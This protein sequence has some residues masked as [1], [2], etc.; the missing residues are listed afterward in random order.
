[1]IRLKYLIERVT[2]EEI[3]VFAATG[4]E[5]DHIT[6]IK[7]FLKWN[8]NKKSVVLS[9]NRFTRGTTI[10]EWDATFLLNETESAEYYFQSAFRPTTPAENKNKG[11]VFDWSANRTLIMVAEYARRSAYRQGITNPEVIMKE[12]QDNFNIFGVDGGVEFRKK[13]VEDILNA[14]RNSDYSANTLK[15]SGNYYIKLDNISEALL[16]KIVGMDKEAS[17]RLKLTISSSEGIM[18]KG[19]N[20]NIKSVPNK[21][22]F[23]KERSDIISRISTLISRLPIICELGYTTVEDIVENLPDEWFYGATKSEKGILRM[24]VEEKIIDTYKINLHLM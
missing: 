5:T 21:K 19:K 9:I 4:N 11:Y 23:D 6:E 10:P 8:K 22:Q 3:K 13:P 16:A 7:E 1:V 2:N 24:L 12:I 14:V 18:K 15:N 17:K 20:Y